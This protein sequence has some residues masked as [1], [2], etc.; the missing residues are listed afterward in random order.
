MEE[1]WKNGL[2]QLS[3]LNKITK[4]TS[5]PLLQ[6]KCCKNDAHDDA[7]TSREEGAGG[8]IVNTVEEEWLASAM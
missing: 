8:G 3:M 2:L 6:L 5:S 1:L 4:P 7:P